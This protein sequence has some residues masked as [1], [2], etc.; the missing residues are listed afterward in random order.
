MLMRYTLIYGV[1]RGIPG[2]VNFMT[3]A[4][5]TRMLQ[6]DDYGYYALMIASVGLWNTVLFEWLR[7]GLLRLYPGHAERPHAL[8]ATLAC[9]FGAIA[10][11]AAIATAVAV[12][13]IP[14]GDFAYMIILG[15]ALLCAQAWFE[16]NL[17]LV[18]S[19]LSPVRYAHITA[20]RAVV[21]LACGVVLIRAGLGAGGA[22]LG[23]LVALVVS[24]IPFVREA[25][26]G[27]R[28]AM[29]DRGLLRE[30]LV[31]GLPLT[32]SLALNFIISSS[33][34]FVLNWLVGAE[35]TGIYAAGY[36]AVWHSMTLLMM[37]VNL[38]G[39]PIAIRALERDGVDAAREQVRQNFILLAAI[40]APAA[41]GIAVGANAIGSV[42]LGA[43]YREAAVGLL[44]WVAL[45]ALIARFKSYYV[46]LSFHLGRK[47][48]GQVWVMLIGAMVNVA[49]TLWW[50]PMFGIYG[51]IYATI[52][53]YAV[54][55]LAGLYAGRR[56]FP[57]P[58]PPLEAVKPVVAAALMA[59]ALW[60]SRLEV[61]PSA[62]AWQL[63]L[64][65]AVYGSVLLGLDFAGCRGRLVGL[66]AARA[67][68]AAGR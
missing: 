51:A 44:P 39:Y 30:L 9:G 12:V 20:W 63:G 5:Y 58:A 56:V 35:A 67:Q 42:V 47:T 23:M 32:A 40:A 65:A 33:D 57:L 18:R 2:V 13:L 8:L 15:L 36:D 26:C 6:P 48:G 50:I 38:A 55:F 4:I 49:L 7:L 21:A 53:A 3:I 37:T 68:N 60:P 61:G 41:V 25:W 29:A 66:V 43:A 46:D 24:V 19:Q 17:E 22:L 31:Y 64:G 28:P 1:G 54:A 52:V 14:G 59:A 27:V 10:V 62:L 11:L 16:L 45:G 34:R